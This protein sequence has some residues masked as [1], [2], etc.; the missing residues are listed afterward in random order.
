GKSGRKGIDRHILLYK[1][2]R[3][4]LDKF[5]FVSLELDRTLGYEDEEEEE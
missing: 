1:N 2:V 3:K 5:F 4:E